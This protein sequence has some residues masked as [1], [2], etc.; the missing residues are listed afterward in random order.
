[1]TRHAGLSAP[2]PLRTGSVKKR[3]G[4]PPVR[5][6]EPGRW[7]Q[8]EEEDHMSGAIRRSSLVKAR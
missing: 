1:M 6:E 7:I 8:L 3:P 2:A 4:F 5:R